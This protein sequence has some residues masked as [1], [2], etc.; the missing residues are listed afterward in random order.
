[1][2]VGAGVGVRVMMMNSRITVGWGVVFFSLRGEIDNRRR[3][4]GGRGIEEVLVIEE[5]EQG[6]TDAF[7][8][9][10]IGEVGLGEGVAVVD[11]VV[12]EGTAVTAE[13]HRWKVVNLRG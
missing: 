10:E 13:G 6:E 9:V 8:G 5:A 12:E 3:G 2:K 4:K 11:S 7:K 1:M